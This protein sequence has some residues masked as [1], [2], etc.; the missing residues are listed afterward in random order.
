MALIGLFY[1]VKRACSGVEVRRKDVE[2]VVKNCN[3]C[4]SIDPSAIRWSTGELSVESV[5]Y[6]V[7]YD[8]THHGGVAYLLGFGGFIVLLSVGFQFGF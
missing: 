3:R 4:R 6:R 5:W 1:F 2:R 7:A 8:V